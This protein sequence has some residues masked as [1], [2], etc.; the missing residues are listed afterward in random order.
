MGWRM[1]GVVGDVVE[2]LSGEYVDGLVGRGVV[3]SVG[4]ERALRAV[5]RHWFVERFWVGGAGVRL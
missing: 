1:E 3:R 4:V 5:P 2:G